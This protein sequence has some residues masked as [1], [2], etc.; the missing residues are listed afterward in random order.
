VIGVLHALRF[1][2]R[3]LPEFPKPGLRQPE[4]LPGFADFGR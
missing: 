2:A 3:D 4:K 1:L